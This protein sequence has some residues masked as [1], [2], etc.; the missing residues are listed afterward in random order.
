MS[1]R[2][3]PC[4]GSAVVVASAAC[5]STA[6]VDPRGAESDAGPFSLSGV[7]LKGPVSGATITASKL[8]PDLTPGDTLASGTTDETGFFGLTLAPY[9]GDVLLVATGGSYAEEALPFDDDGTP[10]PSRRHCTRPGLPRSPQSMATRRANRAPPGASPPEPIATRPGVLSRT[11]L[12]LSAAHGLGGAR[13]SWTSTVM[14]AR[15]RS[16]TGQ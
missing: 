7:V 11:E 14:D 12:L 2:P 16:V 8:R 6:P 5:G 4:V 3:L 1:A 15:V 9:N 13:T 10:R